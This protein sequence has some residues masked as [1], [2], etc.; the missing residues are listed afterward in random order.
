MLIF[1]LYVKAS[2]KWD[3]ERWWQSAWNSRNS[4]DLAIPL[5][6]PINCIPP[7]IFE[8]FCQIQYFLL[9]RNY[10]KQHIL[11]RF[12]SQ[13][14]KIPAKISIFYGNGPFGNTQLARKKYSHD[15]SSYLNDRL[16]PL[17]P[18][19]NNIWLVVWKQIPL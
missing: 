6:K 17:H 15:C 9:A 10:S 16:C 13:I 2:N 3:Y 8:S 1:A 7:E 12:I 5:S 4:V 18:T 19:S 11:N 14:N